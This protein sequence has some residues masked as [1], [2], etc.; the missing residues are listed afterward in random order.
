MML[1]K[2]PRQLENKKVYKSVIVPTSHVEIE[3]PYVV[4]RFANSRCK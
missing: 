4:R 3:R 1:C 2:T